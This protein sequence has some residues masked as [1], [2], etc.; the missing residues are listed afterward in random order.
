MKS[1]RQ[2]LPADAYEAVTS[3]GGSFVSEH[4]EDYYL[5]PYDLGYGSIVKFDHDF[6]GRAALEAMAAHRKRKKMTLLWNA[7][8]TERA[9]GNLLR[10]GKGDA[11]KYIDLPCAV[12]S[13]YPYD[14]VT[15]HGRTVGVSTWAGYS[16]N[17]RAMLSPG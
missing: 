4:I 9:F 16:F 7:E 5:T 10:Y 2:W 14:C 1:F 8:D 13:T 15:K 6:I 12:Y 3:I 17:E 11:P